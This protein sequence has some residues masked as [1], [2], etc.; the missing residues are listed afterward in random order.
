[1]GYHQAEIKY[2]EAN[3]V[4]AMEQLR[5][6][7][8]TEHQPQALESKAAYLA[9]QQELA[10]VKSAHKALQQELRA[11][12]AAHQQ[13]LATMKSTLKANHQELAAMM[14]THQ[15]N[16]QELAAMK[17]THQVNQQELA[18]LKSGEMASLSPS[19]QH[20][21]ET[22]TISPSEQRKTAKGASKTNGVPHP[23]IYAAKA[24]STR[25]INQFCAH[26]R[27]VLVDIVESNFK[28]RAVREQASQGT[29]IPISTKIFH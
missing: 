6:S 25:S 1:M 13:E 19:C 18:A 9:H 28:S 29:K 11:L 20:Y 2:L 5:R 14:S 21:H 24:K 26:S 4:K 23:L 15:A 10:A 16:Q 3:H 27:E 12:K 17:S 8:E 7:H 22:D